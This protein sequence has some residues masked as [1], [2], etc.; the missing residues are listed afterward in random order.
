MDILN[1]INKILWGP[2]S[3]G[4]ILVCALFICFKCGFFHLCHPIKTFKALRSDSGN[5]DSLKNMLTA[6]G[7][8]IGVGNITGVSVAIAH[9]GPGAVFWMWICAII[10]MML[11]YAEIFLG[12]Y[13][14]ENG[15]GG[16][17]YYLRKC[18]L[19]KLAA[20]IFSVSCIASSFGIGCAVQSNAVAESGK[21][22]GVSPLLIGLML[23]IICLFAVFGS[24]KRL[25]RISAAVV[26]IM[27]ITY[28]IGALIIAILNIKSIPSVFS[29][30]FLNAFGYDSLTG[31]I[32]GTAVAAAVRHGI[33]K[34]VFSS[35]CGMGSSA[36]SYCVENNNDAHKQGVW[37]MLEV[38]IDTLVMC[39][40]SAVAILSY[41]NITT[42]TGA[43][44]SAYGKSA[45][46]FIG[47]SLFFFAFTSICSWNFYGKTALSYLT[48]SKTALLLYNAVFV[49]IIVFGAIWNIEMLWEISD[50]FNFLM[51]SVNIYGLVYFSNLIKVGSDTIIDKRSRK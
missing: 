50:I 29:S 6:L 24:A 23:G 40:L 32:T 36:M 13:F 14:K 49:M 48:K 21:K 44:E 30:I 17:M 26:P 27:S 31:G 7:G 35:E 37:G 4:V 43:F 42:V 9:G 19:G 2:F 33:S 12:V 47:I 5:N 18:K 15:V 11:K 3:L 34:G 46:Y 1:S 51:L 38:A 20:V 25:I 10:G 45:V 8:S 16:A 39:T 28:T 41:Q 22:L